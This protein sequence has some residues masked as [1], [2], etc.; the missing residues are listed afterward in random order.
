MIEL[1]HISL[2]VRNIYEGAHRLREETG[3]DNYEAGYLPPAIAN[4]IVPLPNDV[5][6]EVESWVDAGGAN[7]FGQWFID[8][9]A[10]GDAWMF[11]CLRASTME[12]MEAIA[13]RLGS[14]VFTAQSARIKPNGEE[15]GWTVSPASMKPWAAGLP[16]WYYREDPTRHPARTPVNHRRNFTGV[17]WMEVGGDPAVMEEHVTSEVFERLPLRFVDQ[18]PGLYAV[19]IGTDDG[20][21]VVIRASSAASIFPDEVAKIEITKEVME[22]MSAA[23]A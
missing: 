14:V 6:I 2:G 16:N 11:W 10:A 23:E 21:E 5:F 19:A 4:R 12:E 20:D 7:A 8:A 17:T 9:T 15:V 13:E 22:R 1:D 18:P 3:L